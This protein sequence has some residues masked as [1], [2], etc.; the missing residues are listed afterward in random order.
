MTQKEIK[1][2]LDKIQNVKELKEK[3]EE[4]QREQINEKILAKYFNKIKKYEVNVERIKQIKNLEIE[5]LDKYDYV[6]GIDEVGRGPLAGPV[7]A[8][9]TMMKKDSFILKVDDSKKLSEEVREELF[10]TIKKEALFCEVGMSS[11]KE[12]DDVNILNATFKAMNEAYL[13]VKNKIPN[14]KKVLILIDGNLKNPLIK[15]DQISVIKGDSKCYSIACASI[16]AKVTRDRIMDAYDKIYPEYDFI[17][18][19]GYGTEKHRKALK[20]I[21]P[22]EDLHRKSFISNLV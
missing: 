19:K 6:L 15:D 10:E 4:L 22:I 13:K 21:G 3:V 17:N 1:E 16:I 8:C 11:N 9:C 7:V 5:K 14:D 2:M 18:N 12:I 20:E